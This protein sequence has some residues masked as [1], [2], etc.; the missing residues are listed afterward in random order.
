MLLAEQ[1]SRSATTQ[2]SASTQPRTDNSIEEAWRTQNLSVFEISGLCP[3]APV[4]NAKPSFVLLRLEV[5]NVTC[6]VH[7]CDPGWCRKSV[8]NLIVFFQ[9]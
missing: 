6:C 4:I 8:C 1:T 2:H 7:C 5:Y 3:C 9:D